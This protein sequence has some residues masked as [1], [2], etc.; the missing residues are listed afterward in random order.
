MNCLIQKKWHCNDIV[1]K[2]AFFNGENM[3]K[4]E[5]TGQL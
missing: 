2:L 1:S 5:K 4:V 3:D